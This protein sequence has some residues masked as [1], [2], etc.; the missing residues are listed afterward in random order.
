VLPARLNSVISLTVRVALQTVIAVAVDFSMISLEGGLLQGVIVEHMVEHSQL[1][2]ATLLLLFNGDVSKPAKRLLH[3]EDVVQVL[4][5]SDAPREVAATFHAISGEAGSQLVSL[6]VEHESQT[7]S[8][9]LRQANQLVRYGFLMQLNE[10]SNILRDASSSL[11]RVVAVLLRVVTFDDITC[12]RVP[13]TLMD[14]A[15]AT[16]VRRGRTELISLP[17]QDA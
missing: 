10:P 15:T 9:A 13:E 2:V 17:S 11:Y 4:P 1:L 7:R 16:V 6:L 8:A 3:G 14:E 5:Q 12:Q